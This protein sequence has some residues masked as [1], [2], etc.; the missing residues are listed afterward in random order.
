MLR[1]LI[2]SLTLCS[3][4][5]SCNNFFK[6]IRGENGGTEGLITFRPQRVP[7][8]NL[9]VVL[10]IAAKLPTVSLKKTKLLKIANYL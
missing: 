9:K 6:Y 4:C 10:T 2:I 3:F 7:E 5:E 1:Y 8:H